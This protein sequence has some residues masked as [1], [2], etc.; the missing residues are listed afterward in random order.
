MGAPRCGKGRCAIAAMRLV[1]STP[2]VELVT[3]S[4]AGGGEDCF[5]PV[6]VLE[7]SLQTSRRFV[8]GADIKNFAPELR[9]NNSSGLRSG[10]VC[11]WV[12]PSHQCVITMKSVSFPVS[13]LNPLS[14]IIN[15]EAGVRSLDI[16]STVS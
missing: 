7:G 5:L 3:T 8:S 12:A 4:S 16:L 14:E 2:A 9:S 11:W 15:E 10:V 6:A 1:F 13:W